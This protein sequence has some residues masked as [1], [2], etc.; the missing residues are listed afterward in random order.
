MST[1]E[2]VHHINMGWPIGC[3]EKHLSCIH[4]NTSRNSLR[5]TNN[6]DIPC[7][8]TRC[9]GMQQCMIAA[10]ALAPSTFL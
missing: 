8:E 1:C 7:N 3:N 2:Y 10:D 5:I 6:T 9:V 4:M